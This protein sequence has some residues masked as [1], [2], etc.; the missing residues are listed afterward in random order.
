M[1]STRLLAI[2]E[3]LLLTIIWASSFVFIKVGLVYFKP[4]TLAG[5]RFFLAF[6]LL[7]P[8]MARHGGLKKSSAGGQWIHLF[9]MGLCAYT[10]GNG[11]LFWGLKYLPA[12][13]GSFLFGLM[14]L[15]VL[16]LGIIWLKEIPKRWQLVG[17][18]IT[19]AGSSLFFSPGLSAKEPLA[20]AVVSIGVLS[21]AVYGILSR[22]SSRQG[23]VGIIPLTAIPLGFGG[24]LLLLLGLII[25]GMF[26]LSLGGLAIILWLAGINTIFAYLL[27]YH[28][29]RVLTALELHVL[30]NLM[31]LGTAVW[32]GL[33]LGEHLTS[34]QIVGMIMVVGGVTLVQWRKEGWI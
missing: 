18:L 12:T 13:T 11:T 27:F 16:L 32:A 3:G 6:M 10:I 30:L 15:P 14:P 9:L 7:L 23:Y 28:S 34:A 24:G 21:C 26:T 20:V 22:K 29:L 1:K 8:I 5:I 19:L 4:M 25:E 2:A 33:L 17:L 31:P